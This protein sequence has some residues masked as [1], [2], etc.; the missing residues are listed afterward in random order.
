VVIQFIYQ[1][2]NRC[3]IYTNVQTYKIV[4]I[5]IILYYYCDFLVVSTFFRHNH[6]AFTTTTIH[7]YHSVNVSIYHS[8]CLHRYHIRT[9][10]FFFHKK[11]P[12]DF[13]VPMS[14]L[15]CSDCYLIAIT[16][17]GPFIVT[18]NILYRMIITK[19]K[20]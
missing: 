9:M 7:Q 11:I 2:I 4:P 1:N 19:F 5:P 20:I 18:Y 10:Q 8:E 6:L 12:N 14:T 17:C 16:N 3:N 15:T 13:G